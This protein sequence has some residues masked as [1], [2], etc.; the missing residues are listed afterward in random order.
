MSGEIVK[1]ARWAA[2]QEAAAYAEFY[3]NERMRLC[4]DT[5]LHDPVLAGERSP[6]A[7]AASKSMQIDGAINS[8]AFHAGMDIATALREMAQGDSSLFGAPPRH[9]GLFQRAWRFLFG[10]PGI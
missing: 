2:L 8:S 9:P 4:Q 6:E 10:G 3:A 1:L 7:F 5:I